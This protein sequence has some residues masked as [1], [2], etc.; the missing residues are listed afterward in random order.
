MDPV[1]ACPGC[2]LE[3]VL[4]IAHPPERRDGT[5]SSEDWRYL[6]PDCRYDFGMVEEP[7]PGLSG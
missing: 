5:D 4:P 3:T 1:E 7:L 2:G 6:C